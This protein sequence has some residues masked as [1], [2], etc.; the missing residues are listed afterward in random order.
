MAINTNTPTVLDAGTMQ[1]IMDELDAAFRA[2][3]GGLDANADSHYAAHVVTIL[4]AWDITQQDFNAALDIL[5]DEE[6]RDWD[7]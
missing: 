4:A 6:D 5:S 7:V 3:G 1:S 2:S